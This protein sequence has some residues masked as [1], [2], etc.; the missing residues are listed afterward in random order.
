MGIEP[1]SEALGCLHPEPRRIQRHASSCPLE[2]Q[3]QSPSKNSGARAS[4]AVAVTL[5]RHHPWEGPCQALRARPTSQLPI[6]NVLLAGPD[7]SSRRTL[8]PV[9]FIVFYVGCRIDQTFKV[10][11]VIPGLF[12][13]RACVR[14]DSFTRV[15][16][17]KK[18][19]LYLCLF[20]PTQ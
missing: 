12:N 6:T 4:H 18:K 3:K 20:C 7:Y 17:R 1:T 13:V 5:G 8:R 16:E 9:D 11:R 10:I 14:H 2:K 15:P 19:K